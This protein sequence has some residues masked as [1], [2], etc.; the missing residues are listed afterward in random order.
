MKLTPDDIQQIHSYLAQHGLT[1]REVRADVLDH[2]CTLLEQES[3]ELDL[4]TAKAFI[5]TTFPPE[6]IQQIQADTL[7]YLTLKS[8]T[9]MLK[10][11]FTT[12]YIAICLLILGICFS[13]YP[14]GSEFIFYWAPYLSVAGVVI[15]CF[16]FL[17]S[18]F[19]YS[20]QRFLERVKQ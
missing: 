8:K 6:V 12:G 11:I 1:T 9:N 20:Y 16:G 5:E 19:M 15:F 14:M 13:N 2:I 17:P 3:D 4:A 7:Y 10:L 18:L